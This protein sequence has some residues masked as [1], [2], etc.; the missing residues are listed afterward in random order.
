MTANVNRSI[1]GL[2]ATYSMPVMLKWI[3]CGK[4]CIGDCQKISLPILTFAGRV[5]ERNPPILDGQ[6][7][8]HSQPRLF[9][10]SPRFSRTRPFF[11][12][13]TRGRGYEVVPRETSDFG[14]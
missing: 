11:H 9:S 7:R 10:N 1:N 5:R 13:P 6:V 3:T 14:F 12:R 4:W 2:R 8:R